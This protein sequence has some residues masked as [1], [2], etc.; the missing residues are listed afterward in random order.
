MVAIYDTVNRYAPGTQS[1]FYLTV[2]CDLGSDL[3]IDFGCGTGLITCELARRG[4]RPRSGSRAGLWRNIASLVDGAG[5]R[6]PVVPRRWRVRISTSPRYCDRMSMIEARPFNASNHLMELERLASRAWPLGRHPGGLAWEWAIDQLA[7]EMEV[8]VR[9]GVVVGWLGRL[10]P[11]EFTG[12]ADPEHPSSADALVARML[13]LEGDG[14]C[15]IQVAHR[16]RLAEP[17]T[18]SGRSGLAS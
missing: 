7:G 18:R 9:D 16:C 17:I 4:H 2:G 5:R 3:I 10:D 8:L 6:Q 15:Q 1:D 14:A 12:Q 13:E 11:D